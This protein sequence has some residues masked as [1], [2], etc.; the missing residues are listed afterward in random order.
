MHIASTT[1][2]GWSE[3]IRVKT[4]SKDPSLPRL[5]DPNSPKKPTLGAPEVA[6]VR[7]PRP[8]RR[9]T[10]IPGICS[11]AEG[12]RHRSRL[13]AQ[14]VVDKACRQQLLDPPKP[15]EARRDK[16]LMAEAVVG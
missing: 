12:G 3:R 5:P 15:D 8:E 7:G 10:R 9:L 1:A 4:A 6:G 2:S 16:V 14:H 11:G 13:Q